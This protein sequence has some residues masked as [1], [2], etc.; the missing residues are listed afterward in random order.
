M[1]IENEENLC[2]IFRTYYPTFSNA[3]QGEN[4]AP[5][6]FS[7]FAF[8]VNLAAVLYFSGFRKT[9]MVAVVA[10]DH[11]RSL[12]SNVWTHP[13]SSVRAWH[14]PPGSSAS[15]TPG[16]CVLAGGR[17]RVMSR[18]QKTTGVR[19]NWNISGIAFRLWAKYDVLFFSSDAVFSLLYSRILYA[20]R[21]TGERNDC[22]EEIEP[23]LSIVWRFIQFARPKRK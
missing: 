2:S 10:V 12:L 4:R 8:I 7:F 13:R 5:P 18:F 14:G 19:R 21:M 20:Y 9:E 15:I 17:C 3:F 22:K 16:C 23:C 11:F 6:H 1:Y